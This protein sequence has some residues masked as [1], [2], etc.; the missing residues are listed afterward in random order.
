MLVFFL[1]TMNNFECLHLVLSKPYPPTYR[2][3]LGSPAGGQGNPK[4]PGG[5]EHRSTLGRPLKGFCSV[6]GLLSSEAPDSFLAWG[7]SYAARN[8]FQ[9]LFCLQIV[10]VFC[11][12]FETFGV[13]FGPSASVFHRW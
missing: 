2:G 3:Q 6:A 8:Q 5:Q 9:P 10:T 4:L 11:H 7:F 13:L 12:I 1:K